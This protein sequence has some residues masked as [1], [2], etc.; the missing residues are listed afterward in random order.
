MKTLFKIELLHDETSGATSIDVKSEARSVT[1]L[2]YTISVIESV[3]MKL[4][5]SLDGI[6]YKNEQIKEGEEGGK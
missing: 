4:I 5:K 6:I 2:T 1:Q 3:K